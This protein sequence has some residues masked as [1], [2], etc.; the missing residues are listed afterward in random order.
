MLAHFLLAGEKN[1]LTSHW[2]GEKLTDLL[3]A[4]RKILLTSYCPADNTIPSDRIAEITMLS[5]LH[6]DGKK[7]F[8][9]KN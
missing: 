4:S 3:L 6:A 9:L 2:P 1:L 5:S 8:S 7:S